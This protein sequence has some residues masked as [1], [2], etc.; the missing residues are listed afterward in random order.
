M[1]KN[2]I[3]GTILVEFDMAT[4]KLS[5]A[6]MGEY[7]KRQLKSAL[8]DEWQTSRCEPIMST[9]KYKKTK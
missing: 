9:F 4:D 2:K 7:M 5:V 6:E 1:E 8:K 3:K